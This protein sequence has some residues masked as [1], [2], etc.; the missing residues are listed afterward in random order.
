MPGGLDESFPLSL[1]A[2]S[3]IFIFGAAQFKNL[4]KSEVLLTFQE[5]QGRF[6]GI[7]SFIL[8][9]L[10]VAARQLQLL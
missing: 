6:L 10:D 7:G 8:V 4:S 5:V 3:T 1:Q 2:A 9:R